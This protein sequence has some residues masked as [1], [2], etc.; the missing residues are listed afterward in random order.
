MKNTLVI[1]VFHEL[2]DRVNNF[3]KNAIFVSEDTDFVLVSNGGSSTKVS[4]SVN[5]VTIYDGDSRRITLPS[6]VKFLSRPNIGH[7]F[8]A[9]SDGLLIDDLYQNYQ[10]FIFVNSSVDGP[11]NTEW[12]QPFL[13]GLSSTVKLFGCTINTI[14]KPNECAHVQSYAFAMDK[15]ALDYLI[16]CEIFSNTKYIS[17]KMD[18]IWM[19]EIGMSRKIIER[20]WNIGSLLKCY[21]GVDW[22]VPYPIGKP[23]YD[24]IMFPRFENI[25]WKKEELVFIK[26]NR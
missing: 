6:H 10:N 22:T 23:F 3:I 18:V 25:Y 9:W 15:E 1:F 16:Q 24:D 13:N 7:D 14:G 4:T 2:N 8:G 17:N 26:G 5:T 12:T 20:G 19:K 21:E 11:F